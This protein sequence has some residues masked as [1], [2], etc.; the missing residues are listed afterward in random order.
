MPSVAFNL[1][2]E[3][4]REKLSVFK[5]IQRQP[6]AAGSFAQVYRASF[7]D[8]T[9]V[10]IKVKRE[11]VKK[12]VRQD[13]TLLKIFGTIAD[14]LYPQ[15]LVNIPALIREFSRLSYNEL[16]YQM[17][18]RNA[19]YFYDIYAN[20]ETVVIPRT[21]TSL[22]TDNII[23]QDYV[24]GVALTDLIRYRMKGHDYKEWLKKNYRTDIFTFLKSIPYEIGLQAFNYDKYYADPHPGN[25]YILPDNR[26]AIIDF[27]ILGTSPRDKLSYYNLVRLCTEDPDSIDPEELG[28]EVLR[29][30]SNT[31][32]K[33]LNTF[34]SIVSPERTRTS[35]G[36]G[37]VIN[38]TF[39]ELFQPAKENAKLR[40]LAGRQDFRETL[41]DVILLGSKFRVQIPAE[42]VAL[43]RSTHMYKSYTEYLEPD[44]YYTDETFREI[45]AD[46]DLK[47]ILSGDSDRYN[48]MEV[49]D[50]LENLFDWAGDLAENDISLSLKVSELLQ[51]HFSL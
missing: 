2:R 38:D 8:G 21:Y 7:T 13:L 4:T 43:L 32:Y 46:V 49:E 35:K 36:L 30:G 22:S 37:K 20:H 12:K 5:E 34:G 14:I 15:S 1:A 44:W 51:E 11:N 45:L 27:G 19:Q 39:H 25:I 48:T 17:E 18:V 6:F 24:H 47:E 23:V 31:L 42:I 29:F 50:A 26:Y 9:D 40:Q 41:K 33:S 28:Q 10:I 3:L 16:D